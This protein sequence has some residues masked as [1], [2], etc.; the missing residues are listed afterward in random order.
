MCRTELLSSDMLKAMGGPRK[1]RSEAKLLLAL[2]PL[3]P[4]LHLAVD[5]RAARR[6]V[7]RARRGLPAPGAKTGRQRLDNVMDY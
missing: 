2:P 1:N 5:Y 6:A 3:R 7:V 4:L